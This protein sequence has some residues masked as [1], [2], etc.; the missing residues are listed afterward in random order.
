MILRARVYVAYSFDHKLKNIPAN[1]KAVPKGHGF[2]VS[3][4]GSYPRI[5]ICSVTICV[6]SGFFSPCCSS[7]NLSTLLDQ[8]MLQNFGPHMLQKCAVLAPSAG[9]V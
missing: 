9:S 6:K 5:A 4:I 3:L 8:F 2:L 7:L 1:Q